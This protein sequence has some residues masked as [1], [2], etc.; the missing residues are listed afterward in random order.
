MLS[1]LNVLVEFLGRDSNKK[2][3]EESPTTHRA[4]D[5]GKCS[6]ILC[7]I[8]LISTRNGLRTTSGKMDLLSQYCK[9]NRNATKNISTNGNNRGE[10]END[11]MAKEDGDSAFCNRQ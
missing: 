2:E 11:E 9:Y 10:N 7:A 6:C 4:F 8:K 5:R 3:K 1:K